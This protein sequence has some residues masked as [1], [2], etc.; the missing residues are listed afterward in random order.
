MKEKIFTIL[1]DSQIVCTVWDNVK[2]P[3]GV[4]QIIHGIY[5]N[6]KTYNRFARFMNKNGYIVFGIDRPKCNTHPTC[7]DMFDKAVKLQMKIMNY[8]IAQYKLPYF[9]LSLDVSSNSKFIPWMLV[10]ILLILSSFPRST[11]LAI[12]SLGIS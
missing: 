4:I 12:N 11:H 7:P 3:I 5:D 6:M 2:K 1:N 10:S 9:A 8:L